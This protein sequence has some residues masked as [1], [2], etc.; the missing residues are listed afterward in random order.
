[1]KVNLNQALL[2]VEG[3]PMVQNGKEVVVAGLVRQMLYATGEGY[4][5]EEVF[6]FLTQHVHS[7]LKA[8]SFR[9]GSSSIPLDHPLVRRC[10]E[11]GMTPFGSPTLSDQALMSFP[12]IKLG[13]GDSA[14]S[15]AA[16]EYIGINEIDEAID[17][18]FSLLSG[19]FIL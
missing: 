5:N 13:P 6:H 16:D 19:N 4:T 8:R 11:W 2:S 12:S 7:E 1:M 14:R 18:Y 3:K 17:T 10:V 15:H 9:L